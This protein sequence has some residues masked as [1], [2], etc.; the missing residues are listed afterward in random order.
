M[1]EKV[2]SDGMLLLATPSSLPHT[3]PTSVSGASI[4]SIEESLGTQ[5]P[6]SRATPLALLLASS[7]ALGTSH[8]LSE[9]L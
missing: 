6:K 4:L 7:V 2:V 5:P 1:S 3:I 9:S 8:N